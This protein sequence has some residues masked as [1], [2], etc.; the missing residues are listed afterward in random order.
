[1]PDILLQILFTWEY[2]SDVKQEIWYGNI[3]LLVI[4][5]IGSLANI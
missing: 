1:M 3:S 2:K 5:Y 4:E